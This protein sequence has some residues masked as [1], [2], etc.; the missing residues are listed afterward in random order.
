MTFRILLLFLAVAAAPLMMPAAHAEKDEPHANDARLAGDANRTRFIADLSKEVKFTCRTLADPYRVIVDLEEV[1]FQMPEGVGSKGRGLVRSFRFGA[2]A[3]GKSRIVIDTAGPVIVEKAFIREAGENQPARLVIDMVK[4]TPAEFLKHSQQEL[5]APVNRKI[6]SA[7]ASGLEQPM[8]SRDRRPV[9]VLDPGHGGI[10]RGTAGSS[11]TPEKM[12]TLA[13]CTELKDKLEASGRFNVIL[14]RR[15]DDFIALTE[16]VDVAKGSSAALFISVHVDAIDPNNPLLGAEGPKIA[17]TVRGATVYTLDQ[18]ASDAEAQESASRENRSDL[19]AG[20]G[21]SPEHEDEVK[22]VLG[23]LLVRATKRESHDFADLLVSNL[24]SK[25][26]MNL[27]P[28]RSAN[29]VVLRSREFPS[30][31]VELGYL[32]NQEDEKLLL[33]ADWRGKVADIVNSAVMQYF[34]RKVGRLPF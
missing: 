30:V 27:K 23:D 22:R 9:I 32:S 1:N 8:A 12:V 26:E 31:L 13:F 34:D 29:F 6:A 18:N 4:A 3:A 33:S 15:N 7:N 16:R 5:P 24:N 28:R 21:V 11:G 20:L 17:Q 2:Y 19:I 25:I 14:T 10:D